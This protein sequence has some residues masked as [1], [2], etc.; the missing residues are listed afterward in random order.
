MR[1]KKEEREKAKE[2]KKETEMKKRLWL[3]IKQGEQRKTGKPKR[4]SIEERKLR[5]KKNRKRE[6]KP[7]SN[8][9]ISLKIIC[10]LESKGV[11]VPSNFAL[12]RLK[13]LARW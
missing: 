2:K 11:R 6:E 13:S 8:F 4:E 7:W 9:S 1:L 5:R 3:V 10:A 12:S